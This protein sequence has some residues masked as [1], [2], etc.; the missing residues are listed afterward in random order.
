MSHRDSV[1]WRTRLCDLGLSIGAPPLFDILARFERETT[2][3]GLPFRAVPYLGT[4]WGVETGTVTIS[5]PFY[6]ARTDLMDLHRA[7]TGLVEG[8]GEE[9]V[10]RYLRHELGHVLDYAYKLS[11]DAQWQKLFGNPKEP[12]KEDYHPKPLS[13]QFVTHL[14]GWYAQ[15]HPEEDWAETCAVLLTPGHDAL[16]DYAG[17]TG[18]LAKLR[19]AQDILAGLKDRKRPRTVYRFSDDV[20]GHTMTVGEVYADAV[21]PGS[22]TLFG[23]APVLRAALLPLRSAGGRDRAKVSTLLTASAE[24]LAATVYR[25]TGHFPE[26]I[27]PVISKLAQIAEAED[28]RYPKG[29]QPEAIMALAMLL[30]TL[31]L[32][33]RTQTQ[34]DRPGVRLRTAVTQ[35]SPRRSA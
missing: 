31:A 7:E 24:D 9:D 35:R 19:Y 21:T 25:L 1:L 16:G 17:C 33:Q 15:K 28:L 32:T 23:M 34:H 29:A 12:Y 5:V 22:P 8:V 10:L 26:D 14:P 18:A 13:H 20:A 11:K 2:G 30:G 6:L 27:L 4:E 3:L